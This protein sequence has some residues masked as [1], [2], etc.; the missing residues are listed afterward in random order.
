MECRI[1]ELG[2][3]KK[4]QLHDY[5]DVKEFYY[6]DVK[7]SNLFDNKKKE[8]FKKRFESKNYSCFGIKS[9][10][11]IIYLTWISWNHMNYPSIFNM[12]EPMMRD[13][14]LL[15]DSFCNPI[16]RG[17]GYHS[18][19]NIYRLNIMLA[20]GIKKA[21]VLI[22]KENIPAIKVQLKSGFKISQIIKYR[23]FFNLSRIKKIKYYD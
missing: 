15:E 10:H 20:N 11:E 19:M 6:D 18:K 4:I 1:D 23:K 12:R 3:E 5:S 13:E 14:A 21:I 7:D 16:Y 9:N 17:M 22:L 8:L 2:I